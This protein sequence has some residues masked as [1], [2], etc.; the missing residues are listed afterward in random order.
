MTAR[1]P[2]LMLAMAAGGSVGG[3]LGSWPGAVV[4]VAAAAFTLAARQAWRRQQLLDWLRRMQLSGPLQGELALSA[5]EPP[6]GGAIDEVVDRTLRL[7]KAQARAQQDSHQRLQDMLAAIQASPNGVILLDVEG[8]I[9]WCN[10]TAAHHLGLDVARDLRQYVANLIRDPSFNAYVAAGDFSFEVVVPGRASTPSRPVRLSVQLHPYGQGRRLLLSR[11]VTLVEQAEAMR[12][13]FVANVSHEM[14]TPLTVLA[15]FVE[16]LQTLDLS[17]QEVRRYL[18]LMATQSQRMQTLVSD[19][20]TLSRLEGSPLPGMSESV[21]VDAL[22][23]HCEIDARALSSYMGRVEHQMQFELQGRA[24]LCGAASELQSAFSNLVSNAVRYTPA[25]GRVSV[26]WR[27]L[28]DGGGEFSVQDSGP[29]IPP[30]HLPRLTERFYRVDRSRSRDSGGTG[31]GL[32]IVKHVVQR[33]GAVLKI[34]SE[35]GQGS[36]FSI[37]LPAGRVRRITEPTEPTDSTEPTEPS[38]EVELKAA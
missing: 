29:G 27:L 15:G 24:E 38:R 36:R 9:E 18:D 31:L 35:V 13:D 26:S 25:P 17:P 30:E 6:R 28:P 4:G 11:D 2:A 12:R 19:L 32:A 1:L 21:S 20:L 23:A 37:V 7:L 8:R 16:T 22:M 5:H 33:H 10:Q 3:L 34:E 14:R